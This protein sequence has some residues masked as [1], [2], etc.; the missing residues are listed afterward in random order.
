MTP[1]RLVNGIEAAEQEAEAEIQHAAADPKGTFTRAL[2]RFGKG[3][4]DAAGAVKQGVHA[5]G[6]AVKEG[7]HQAADWTKKPA[8]EQAED[9]LKVVGK[10]SSTAHRTVPTEVV[11]GTAAG[12]AV[13]LLGG[14]ASGVRGADRLEQVGE[15]L[16]D[17]KKARKM[18]ARKVEQAVAEHGDEATARR[19][20]KEAQEQAVKDAEARAAVAAAQGGAGAGEAVS[21][22]VA[23]G[24]N[25]V[26]GPKSLSRHKLAGVLSAFD[27]DEIAAF[28]ALEGAAQSLADKGAIKGVFQTTMDVAGQTVT[29]RG[30]VVSGTAKVGTAFIP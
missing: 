28:K 21:Q 22:R 7:V 11:T 15:A 20:L 4:K 26:F 30:A 25:H 5:T 27:G 8:V 12:G 2:D 17:G 16:A 13:N 10:Q 14:L 24:A 9:V 6:L 29:V 1:V 19:L 18:A 23:N 3:I